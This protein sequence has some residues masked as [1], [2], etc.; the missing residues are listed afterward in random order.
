MIAE[1]AKDDMDCVA[2]APRRQRMAA[3]AR[4][5]HILDVA[6]SLFFER[7]W[8]AVTIAD[9]L[10]EAG[11]SKGGFYHHFAA[12]EDLL[13][14]VIERF[15]LNALAS[16]EEAR[17]AAKGCALARL[18]AFLAESGRWKP[19][20][21]AAV[22]FLVDA[23]RRPGNDVLFHRIATATATAAQP[24][25]RAMI[26]EGVREGRFDVPDAELVAEAILGLLQGWRPVMGAAIVAAERGE[27]DK[28]AA[29]LGR[30]IA[31]EG[32]LL[33]RLLGLPPGSV[34]PLDPAEYRRALEAIARPQDG[35][36]DR[37]GEERAC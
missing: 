19:E 30:R 27:L 2:D 7:G 28:A 8:D 35:A 31:A 37:R 34:A 21:T 3:D 36:S 16:A 9:V 18:N 24:L 4:R 15:A 12:K 33:D 29:V 14:G 1:V 20:Q 32:L 22:R 11:I 13:D 26:E 5:A 10:G 17:A 6:Q 23:A 25:L